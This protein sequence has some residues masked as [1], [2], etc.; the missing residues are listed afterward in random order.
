MLAFLAEL[1]ITLALVNLLP[2]QMFDG[3]RILCELGERVRHR[4]SE[5]RS[6]S[7]GPARLWRD[8]QHDI[9]RQS[10]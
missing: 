1:S 2:V 9:A 10:S 6:E 3:R 8:D 7:S 5:G 4:I